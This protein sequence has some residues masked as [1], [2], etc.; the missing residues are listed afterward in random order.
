MDLYVLVV[1]ETTSELE[2]AILTIMLF[3]GAENTDKK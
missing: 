1:H 3:A 2:R